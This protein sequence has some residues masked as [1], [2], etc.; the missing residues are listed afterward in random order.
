MTIPHNIPLLI[1]ED[2]KNAMRSKDAVALEVTR[3]LLAAFTNEVVAQR[4][5]PDSVLEDA[6]CITVIKRLIKQRKDAS[7]Q[8]TEGGRPELAEKEDAECAVLM[9]YLPAQ[10]SEEEIEKIVKEKIAEMGTVDKA[11]AGKLVGA[12]VKHFAGNADGTLIK[13]VVDRV[14]G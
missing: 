8:F 10:A 4:R 7:Q 13:T 3:G 6:D 5:A 9:K 12:V 1:R 11:G 14:I 2:M